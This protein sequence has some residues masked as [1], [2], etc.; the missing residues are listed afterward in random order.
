MK[1]KN[2]GK[3]IEPNMF[4]DNPIFACIRTNKNHEFY[5]Y[6]KKRN[7]KL[8]I[9][10]DSKGYSPMLLAI[11]TNNIEVAKYIIENKLESINVLHEPTGNTG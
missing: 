9:L 3:S 8:G 10:R 7:F 2:K 4:A 6:L 5:E 11:I 1:L